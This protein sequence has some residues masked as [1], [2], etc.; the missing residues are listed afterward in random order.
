VPADDRLAETYR[1]M[2][3]KAEVVQKTVLENGKLL[4]LLS[5]EFCEFARS[6]D[7]TALRRNGLLKIIDDKAFSLS[8][9]GL[10]FLDDMGDV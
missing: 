5:D 2:G 9:G 7:E 6:C 10:Y 4:K 3:Y 1:K 8:M